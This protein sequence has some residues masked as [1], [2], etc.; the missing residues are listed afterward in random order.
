LTLK[1]P[2]FTY[3]D[4]STYLGEPFLQFLAM[5]NLGWDGHP[6]RRGNELLARAAERLL[7]CLGFGDR[8]TDCQTF[9]ERSE[10]N[11]AHWLEYAKQRRQFLGDHFGLSIDFDHFQ[12]IFQLLGG[13]FPPRF[14]PGQKA[15][16]AN[17]LFPCAHPMHLQLRGTIAGTKPLKL[18]TTLYSAGSAVSRV[19]ELQPGE[20]DHMTN[21]DSPAAVAGQS[22]EAVE[23]QLRC[24]AEECPPLRLHQLGFVNSRLA[25]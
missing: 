5:N 1:D 22:C 17:F 3:A 21:F 18:E 15:G 14:F 16:R 13:I 4:S 6:S 8:S 24:L 19:S 25:P 7:N 2:T 10:R 20:V 23:V 11:T 12:G 9:A